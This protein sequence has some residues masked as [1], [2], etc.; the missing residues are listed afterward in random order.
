MDHNDF[1]KLRE[2]IRD[3]CFEVEEIT[4]DKSSLPYDNNL[5]GEG[6]AIAAGEPKRKWYKRG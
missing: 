3:E 6:E 1:Q 4:L 2:M 5:Q